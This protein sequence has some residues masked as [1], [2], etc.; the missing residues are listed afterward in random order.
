M[1]VYWLDTKG[2]LFLSTSSNLI[3]RFGLDVT[4]N[5]GGKAK[6]IPIS[7]VQWKA[8]MLWTLKFGVIFQF[9]N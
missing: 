3:Q 4:L 5:C 1:F 2:V 6:I 7:F 9:Q 8:I